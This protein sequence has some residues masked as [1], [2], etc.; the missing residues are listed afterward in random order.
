MRLPKNEFYDLVA[1][2]HEHGLGVRLI[3]RA[4]GVSKSNVDRAKQALGL[5]SDPVDILDQLPEDLRARVAKFGTH[6]PANV[7][8]GKARVPTLSRRRATSS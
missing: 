1:A 6:R 3:A 5:R 2:L 7:E 4:L 8:Q